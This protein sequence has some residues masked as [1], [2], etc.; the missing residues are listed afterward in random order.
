MS[1][2]D[3][4]KRK[5]DHIQLSMKEDSQ[6][7]LHNKNSFS[8]ELR[9]EALPEIDFQDVSIEQKIFKSLNLSSPLFISSMTAGHKDALLINT[10]LA[11]VSEKRGW[12]MGAGSQR[13]ELEDPEEGQREWKA[14]R[15]KA[16]KAYFLGNLG[17]T[18]V[19]THSTDLIK[20]LLYP[21]EAK[22]LIV[23]TNPLQEVLQKKGTPFFKGGLKALEKLCKSLEVPVILKE[24]G[25]GFSSETLSRLDQIGLYAVDVSGKGGTH[26]GRIEQKRWDKNDFLYN[27]GETFKN[28]GISTEDSLIATKELSLHYNIWASGGIRTGKEACLCLALGAEMVGL[29]Q[30]LMKEALISEEALDKK[31]Q[32]L[33]CE[34]KVAL[35]CTGSQNIKVLKETK[36]FYKKP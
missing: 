20:K 22:G 16:P 2:K 32:T 5:R 28:W 14:V 13:R 23:H 15:K 18:Q 17:L 36:P 26:W 9:H 25:C 8:F 21:L 34:L 6:A 19:I 31:M 3:F 1:M 7:K 33:E 35:F 12:L 4:E 29:A 27:V 11:K 24:V 30:P 10:R